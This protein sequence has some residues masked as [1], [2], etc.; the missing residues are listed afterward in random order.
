M[1][2][3]SNQTGL[4]IKDDNYEREQ[5]RLRKQEYENYIKFRE[6]MVKFREEERKYRFSEKV[7]QIEDC[8][9][10]QVRI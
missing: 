6:Q 5:A 2:K 7:K 9:E 4:I 8:E 3:R 10:L 1:K